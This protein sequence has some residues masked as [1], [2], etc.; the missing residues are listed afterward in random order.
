MKLH[1]NVF[2]E[3]TP[4]LVLHGFLGMGDNWK[5]LAKKISEQGYQMHLIDQRN[6]GRSPHSDEFNYEILAL[7]L[8]EY[9]KDHG[10]K[11]IVLLGHSMGG[12]TAMLFAA[13]Y[14]DIVGKLIIADIG[15][16]Y[17]PLHHQ[18]ILDGLDSLDFE[19]LKSRGDVDKAL[20]P[21]VR[22]AGVRMFLMKN[23]FWKEKGQLGLRMNLN[24]LIRNSSEIG[25]A[26]SEEYLYAG[27]TLFLRGQKSNY[28]IDEDIDLIKKQFPKSKIGEI[29]N[30]GHWL[31][32][33]N[34]SEFLMTLLE[35]LKN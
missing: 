26:L 33:E 6:H 16:K 35:F 8:L 32:A 11:D 21:Y 23:L 4:F 29:S 18:D 10:L 14:P 24:S 1:A 30:A 25:V 28:I 17:Y 19:V 7:D 2:G 12:K 31:H 15:P 3:G 5:T 13:K 34:P 9:C 22:D 20:E 27:D